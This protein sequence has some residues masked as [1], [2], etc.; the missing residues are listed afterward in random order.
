MAKNL[1]SKGEKAAQDA[2]KKEAAD[3]QKIIAE[4]K[5]NPEWL[6]VVKGDV[7]QG[8]TLAIALERH[9]KQE[10]LKRSS[11]EK[12]TTPKKTKAQRE[13]ERHKSS[14]EMIDLDTLILESED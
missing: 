2:A 13:N 8:E 9:A 1:V 6:K 7:A 4:I 12:E 3:L 10:L 5:K 14:L 11:E